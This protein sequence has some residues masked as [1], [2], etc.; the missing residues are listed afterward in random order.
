MPLFQVSLTSVRCYRQCSLQSVFLGY[1]CRKTWLVFQ[2]RCKNLSVS[3][4]TRLYDQSLMASR[5]CLDHR[6]YIIK[7]Y[8]GFSI[9]FISLFPGLNNRKQAPVLWTYCEYSVAVLIC[10]N[11]SL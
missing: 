9:H 8:I 6:T 5:I 11:V 1:I 4:N 10:E 2:H 3:S 7:I